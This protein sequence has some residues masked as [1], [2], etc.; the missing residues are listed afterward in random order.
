MKKTNVNMLGGLAGAIVLNVI[1][2]AAK[3]FMGNAPHVDEIGKEALSKTIKQAGRTPPVGNRLFLFTLAADVVANAIYYSLVGR[4]GQKQLL[5]KGAG[6]GSLAGIGALALTRPLGLDD[7][8]VNR[9]TE[10]QAM[11]VA[12]Y[13]IG[14][15]AAAYAIKCLNK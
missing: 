5:L 12:W 4:A 6:W 2:Q 9:T 13:A 10:T 11:T 3:R 14:G 7:R 15:I 1:H 8:P